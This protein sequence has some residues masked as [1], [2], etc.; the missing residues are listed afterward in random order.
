MIKRYTNKNNIDI[1]EVRLNADE[2]IRVHLDND[3]D[4]KVGREPE[5]CL[6]GKP[7]SKMYGALMWIEDTDEGPEHRFVLVGKIVGYDM[8]IQEEQDEE[9]G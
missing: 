8:I 6:V 9:A 1:V 3:V 4:I 2:V 7:N 5:W